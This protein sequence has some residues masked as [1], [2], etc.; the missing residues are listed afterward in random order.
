[1]KYIQNM[2]SANKNDPAI[3][4]LVKLPDGT[5]AERFWMEEGAPCPMTRFIPTTV[6]G[7]SDTEH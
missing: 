7:V 1:M 4:I 3:D 5:V 6:A 2:L